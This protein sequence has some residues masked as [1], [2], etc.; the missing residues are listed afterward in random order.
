MDELIVNLHMHTRYSDG[1]GTHQQIAEAGLDSGLDVVI[2]TDHNVLVNGFEGYYRRKDRKLLM[3]VGEEVH[4]QARQPQKNHLLVIGAG[5]EMAAYASQPQQLID[6]VR[7]SNGL[8]FIAHPVENALP[9]FHEDDISWVNWDVRGF[10]GIELWNGLSEFKN[11]VHNWFEAIFYAF[12][13]E[14]I[15]HGPLPATL[16]R[17]D[18]ILASGEKCVAVG[19]S[20]AH[21]LDYRAG[22]IRRT[23]F[24]YQFHFQAINTHLLTPHAMNGDLIQDRQLVLQ[25]LQQGHCF[26]GYDLPAST[27]GFRFSAQGQNKTAM[28]GDEVEL[29]GSTTLQIKLPRRCECRL[30]KD[31]KVIQTWEDREVC[32]LI[33]NQP[34]VYRVECYL[35]FLGKRRGWIF[36]NP[37]YLR[38][39]L[40][41]KN[42]EN[43]P[44]WSQ[45][46][47]PVF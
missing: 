29:S 8:A 30:L 17:W 12:N 28:M 47:L 14:R 46:T 33:T 10:T 6:R 15:A 35:E 42:K 1:S 16:E 44:Q 39:T 18:R 36:S 27:R 38:P 7:Q 5:R 4:D 31:G 11:V 34:G 45:T 24:P 23:I 43:G 3:L 22:S 9:L 21:A 41:R 32:T 19:G 20:D 26:I 2:V 40:N 25:N 13:P 37:I